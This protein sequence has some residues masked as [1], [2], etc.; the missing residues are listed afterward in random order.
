MCLDTT[1]SYKKFLKEEWKI[2]KR[3]EKNTV[4]RWFGGWEGLCFSE[5]GG[6]EQISVENKTVVMVVK[7]LLLADNRK[8]KKNLRRKMWHVTNITQVVT[9]DT[10]TDWSQAEHFVTGTD[11]TC[12]E[13]DPTIKYDT[14]NQSCSTAVR[15]DARSRAQHQDGN[16]SFWSHFALT[17]LTLLLGK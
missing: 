14:I 5:E 11:V 1:N 16:C 8:K 3:K 10:T 13:H 15:W 6:W 9:S 7:D 2:N 17:Y 4:A 12:D